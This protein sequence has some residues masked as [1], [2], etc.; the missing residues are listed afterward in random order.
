MLE[1]TADGSGIYLRAKGAS[2]EGDRPFLAVMSTANGES[3]KVWQSEDKVFES[4]R[5]VLDPA[6]PRVLVW[7]ESPELSPNYYLLDPANSQ[8]KQVT[9]FPNPYGNAPLPKKQVLKYKRADGVDLSA[10]LYLPPG[11]KPTDGPLPTLMEAYPT[12]YKTKSAA[13][14][15]IGL[16]V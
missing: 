8:L 6:N 11:Y 12:E 3:K 7:K 2:P 15:I 10:N 4:A 1:T 14:Q 5:A 9:F 16:A 13:G